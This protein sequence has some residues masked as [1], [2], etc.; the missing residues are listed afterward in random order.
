MENALPT[1]AIAGRVDKDVAIDNPFNPVKV[2]L[3]TFFDHN[4]SYEFREI[5]IDVYLSTDRSGK[6]TGVLNPVALVA[7]LRN[8]QRLFNIAPRY[9][10]IRSLRKD[11]LHSAMSMVKLGERRFT[12][13]YA[14]TL[15]GTEKALATYRKA[16]QTHAT[17][18]NFFLNNAVVSNSPA[19]AA[20][21]NG[22]NKAAT[23]AM[24][25]ASPDLPTLLVRSISASVI[26]ASRFTVRLRI[27][28]TYCDSSVMVQ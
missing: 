8:M 5:Q 13:R 10:D 27:L 24:A 18:L 1:P 4:P 20:I 3:K 17:A 26:N 6:L 7:E 23:I 2:D 21:R 14:A 28:S 16:Q 15:G 11:D 25:S 19:P 22:H 9:A 12:E